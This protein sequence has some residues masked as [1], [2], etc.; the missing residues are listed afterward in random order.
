MR[1]V[2]NEGV[3]PL[4]LL[5]SLEVIRTVSLTRIDWLDFYGFSL[6][7]TAEYCRYVSFYVCTYRHNNSLTDKD[8]VMNLIMEVEDLI[9]L[10]VTL[11]YFS[12][13]IYNDLTSELC[14]MSFSDGI[15]WANN[16]YMFNKN[17]F[18]LHVSDL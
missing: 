10:W 18:R 17:K 14:K 12:S 3:N 16:R 9:S 8:W 5:A 2:G 6:V 11:P 4:L 13:N 15:N 7:W 1:V